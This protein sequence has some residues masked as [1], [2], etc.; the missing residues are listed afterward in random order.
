[1][2]GLETINAMN[3]E[4]ARKARKAKKAPVCLTTI[5]DFGAR[6]FPNLGDACADFD[7]K[8]ELIDDLFCDC[9]GFGSPSEPAVDAGPT[10]GQ[11]RATHRGVR[12]GALRDPVGGAVPAL[13]GRLEGGQLGHDRGSLSFVL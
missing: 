8:F 9:S 10:Q 6:P 5:E 2:Y 3:D 7:K 11:A 13:L 4:A 1:M 12:A